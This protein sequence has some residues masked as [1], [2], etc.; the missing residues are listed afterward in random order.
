MDSV[1]WIR[2]SDFWV[3]FFD[4]LDCSYCSDIRVNCLKNLIT[5]DRGKIVNKVAHWL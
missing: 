4:I 1:V 3:T 2:K 5:G